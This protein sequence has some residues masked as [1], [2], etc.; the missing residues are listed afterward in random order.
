MGKRILL[1]ALGAGLIAACSAS[2]VFAS[3]TTTLAVA[4]KRGLTATD[5]WQVPR[6]G[7]PRL[8]PDGKFAVYTV[9][10]WSI[11]KDK[12]TTHLWLADLTAGT[13]RQL[14]AAPNA[15]DGSPD[16]SPDGKRIAFT[17][18]RGDDESAALY[19]IEVA[20]GEAQEIIELPQ[21]IALPRW[22]PDGQAIVFA[23]TVIPSLAGKLAPDD[24]T[25]TK[26]E[27][28]RRKDSKMTARVS[29]DRSYRFWDAWRTDGTAQRLVR[30]DLS[31]KKLT[32]L[33]PAWDRAFAI[34]SEFSYEVAPDGKNIAISLNSTPP[35]YRDDPNN[36]LYLVPTD[37]SG[38]LKNLTADNPQ[39]DFEPVF[40]P[41]GKAIL[42]LRLLYD[43]NSGE[44]AKLFRLDLTT[45]RA[46]RLAAEVDLSFSAQ[47]YSADGK[48]IYFAAEDRGHLPVFR[49]NADGT[50]L[51]ALT[52]DGTVSQ[53]ELAPDGTLLLLH[54]NFSRPPELFT[55]APGVTT[56]KAIT[57]HSAAALA[58]FQFGKVESHVFKGVKGDDVQLWLIYPPGFDAAKKYPLVQLLHGGP[59]TMVRDA[60]SWRWHAHT[61]AARG[62]IVSWVNRHG[63]TGFGEKFARS[64]HGA[65][66]KMPGEDILLATD[67]LVS[68]E[69][70]I[71][72]KRVAAGGASYGGY[73]S[74]WLLG[75]TDRF[76]T[77][78][79]HAGVNDIVAQYASDSTWERGR[80]LG[81]EIWDKPE[82]MQ[83]NNPIAY[84]ANFKTPMLI[85][86]GELDYR[87]PVN[88]GLLLYGI[89]QAKGVPTRLVYFPNENH[90]ILKPQNSIFW[91]NEVSNWFARYIATE[92][93]PEPKFG[94]SE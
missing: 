50:G 56:L 65:W 66:G 22:L 2:F 4:A 85:T 93:L 72:A 46:T 69:P 64:I 31:T 68:K 94:A 75:H 40:S 62:M 38:A 86:H 58:P 1:G 24:L 10:T 17:S 44:S 7:S 61:F 54:E 11:E 57:T 84:A 91:Y 74:A 28:K 90:W 23:T 70:A 21:G 18:K 79:N 33:M 35:P 34:S 27:L 8:S 71:D 6:V 3:T 63:S 77:L 73:L 83:V 92:T 59:H 41:D 53:F 82:A 39:G 36:D 80:V 49:L 25:A 26:K 37:G 30:I 52:K 20:G 15:T 78:V 43:V 48:F 14:T 88:H 47:T 81:G 42:F 60:W 16:F 12:A 55:L 45:G 87:V 89:L 67:Y 51:T 29:E 13:T 19:V 76:V 9:Q 5:L 32:D